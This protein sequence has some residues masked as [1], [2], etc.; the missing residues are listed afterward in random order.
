MGL[1]IL[2][3][4]WTKVGI[5]WIKWCNQNSRIVYL[6]EFSDGRN[7]IRKVFN[8]KYIIQN[9]VIVIPKIIFK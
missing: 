1:E 4:M 3:N 9:I 8:L 7:R 5:L 6:S 2:C